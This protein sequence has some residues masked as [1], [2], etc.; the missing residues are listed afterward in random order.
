MEFNI[1]DKVIVNE[2]CHEPGLVGQVRIVTMVIPD[3][4]FSTKKNG[5]NERGILPEYLTKL[6]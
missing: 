6:N 1:G 3:L 4:V 2:N 5:R